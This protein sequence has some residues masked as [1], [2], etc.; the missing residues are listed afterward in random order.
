MHNFIKKI[1]NNIILTDNQFACNT[2]FICHRIN[3]INDL[4]AIL[5]MFGI[6]VD[7]RDD[8]NTIYF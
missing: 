8:H 6:E 4:D 3:N 2:K 7:I 1:N 5:H